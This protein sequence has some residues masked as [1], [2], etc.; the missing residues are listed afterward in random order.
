[1]TADDLLDG[2]LGAKDFAKVFKM[3]QEGEDTATGLEKKLDAI[4]KGL[5]ELLAQIDAKDS[6][7]DTS[8][9]REVSEP[10]KQGKQ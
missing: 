1:M 8:S 10:G 4:E 6:S 3:L 5:D 2:E 7:N 9:N